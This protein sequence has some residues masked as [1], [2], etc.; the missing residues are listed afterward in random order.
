M[1]KCEQFTIHAYKNIYQHECKTTNLSSND[2]N[3]DHSEK[4]KC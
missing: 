2:I 4:M 1:T 3:N